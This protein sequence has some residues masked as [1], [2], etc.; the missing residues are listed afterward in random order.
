MLPVAATTAIAIKQFIDQPGGLQPVEL[1]DPCSEH[2]NGKILG[3]G[4]F[5]SL[6]P[7][8]LLD[9]LTLFLGAAPRAVAIRQAGRVC[10]A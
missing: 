10:R 1:F 9:Q 8:Q 3:G 2:L 6:L 7:D 4:F 5:N